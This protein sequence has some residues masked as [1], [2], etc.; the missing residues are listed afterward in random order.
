MVTFAVESI[1]ACAINWPSLRYWKRHSSG[2]VGTLRVH[3]LE[4][5]TS[6]TSSFLHNELF[7]NLFRVLLVEQERTLG[8]TA[9]SSYYWVNSFTKDWQLNS[10]LNE[11]RSFRHLNKLG[12]LE[13]ISKLSYQS[14]LDLILSLCSLIVCIFSNS[15]WL[16]LE[17]TRCIPILVNKEIW[18]ILL[19]GDTS[20]I[21]LF[22]EFLVCFHLS[23][24]VHE[25]D[26]VCQ[27][28]GSL[29]SLCDIGKI[30]IQFLEMLS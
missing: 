5:V 1:D 9:F 6:I 10:I 29:T 18:L 22:L 20:N 7:I 11:I 28:V 2:A 27:N 17:T 21:Q 26:T 25:S 13:S 12:I 16:R 14:P 30:F 19:I 15:V 24:G 3:L 8:N 23:H 4:G